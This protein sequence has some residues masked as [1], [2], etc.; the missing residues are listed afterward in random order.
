MSGDIE[1]TL[2]IGYDQSTRFE[3]PTVLAVGSGKVPELLKSRIHEFTG[4]SR[5]S[6]D[7]VAEF[8]P[9]ATVR[10]ISEAE[11]R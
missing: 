8:K 3:A 9:G 7:S 5:W 11:R 4:I 1:R 10:I 6:V 2:L